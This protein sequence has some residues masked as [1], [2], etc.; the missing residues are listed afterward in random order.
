[1]PNYEA[2]SGDSRPSSSSSRDVVTPIGYLPLKSPVPNKSPTPCKSRKSREKSSSPLPIKTTPLTPKKSLTPIKSP[3]SDNIISVDSNDSD[4]DNGDLGFEAINKIADS[5][6]TSKT[7]RGN[8]KLD[9]PEPKITPVKLKKEGKIH[10]KVALKN[11]QKIADETT[12]E[13]DTSIIDITNNESPE[14]PRRG[15]RKRKIESIDSDVNPADESNISVK[16]DK[17][18]RMEKPIVPEEPFKSPNSTIKLDESQES[19]KSTKPTKKVV[20]KTTKSDEKLEKT[21]SD[22]SDNSE[23]RT[24]RGT[25][26]KRPSTVYDIDGPRDV[27]INTDELSPKKSKK[28]D[29]IINES[30]SRAVRSKSVPQNHVILFTGLSDV[31]YKN[32]AVKLGATVTDNPAKATILVTD[33]VRRTF[34]FFCAVSRSIPI[35]SVNWIETS[36]KTGH[37]VDS[38]KFILH[39]PIAEAKFEFKLSKSLQRASE[40]KLLDGYT[41]VITPQVNQPSV[42][43]IKSMINVSGGKALIRAPRVWLP[44]TVIISCEADGQNVKKMTLKAPREIPVVTV[45]FIL[46]GILKQELDL[47]RYKIKFE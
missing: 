8:S 20:K 3:L 1:M 45:E 43:E 16:S 36:K 34:K 46:S 9:K 19:N 39:D 35:A 11:K 15:R 13:N 27:T 2:H 6:L 12:K 4:D 32:T 26:K 17:K 33:K 22:V 7:R 18:L 21:D 14:K 28:D 10:W 47:H 37:F 25:A 23:G 40:K 44:N 24:R 30:P 29:T 5:C 38:D 41:I 31:S 42:N